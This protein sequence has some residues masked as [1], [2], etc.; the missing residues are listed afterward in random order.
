MGEAVESLSRPH[1]HALGVA[2]QTQSPGAKRDLTESCTEL[3]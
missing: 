2:V 1:F 3:S